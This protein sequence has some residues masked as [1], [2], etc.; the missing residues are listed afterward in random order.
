MAIQVTVSDLTQKVNEGWKK[1]QLATYY[2]LPMTQVTKLLQQAG[3]KIRKFHLPKFVLVDDT[4]D[5]AEHVPDVFD[6]VEELTMETPVEDYAG[7]EI[8]LEAIAAFD[9]AEE[10]VTSDT[11][12]EA[13]TW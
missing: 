2:G 1:P 3:L 11:S 10:L 4:Q 12:E 5:V 7:Y 9:V 8:P 6:Y 13:G